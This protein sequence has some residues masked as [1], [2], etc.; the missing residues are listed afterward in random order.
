MGGLRQRI[1]RVLY[2]PTIKTFADGRLDIFVYSGVLDDYSKITALERPLELLDKYQIDY[3]LFPGNRP[4]TYLLDHSAEWRPIYEDRVAK[5]YESTRGGSFLSGSRAIDDKSLDSWRDFH[6]RLWG[7]GNWEKHQ[8]CRPATSSLFPILWFSIVAL[9]I[10]PAQP[11]RAVADPLT[12]GF[13]LR[14]AQQLLTSHAFLHADLV[15]RSPAWARR[16]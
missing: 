2:A 16:S 11:A 7:F 4:L 14:N 9:E 10:S 15:H 1:Y 5:L 6:Q 13:T 12:Y 8:R 3:V